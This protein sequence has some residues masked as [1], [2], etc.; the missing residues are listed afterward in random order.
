MAI[1]RFLVRMKVLI[2]RFKAAVENYKKHF[3]RN[4]RGIWLPECAYRP[5]YDWHSM[6]PVAPYHQKHLRPGIEQFLAKFDIEYFVTDQDLTERSWQ[7]SELI[8]MLKSRDS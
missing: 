3:G 4:P 6:I 1:C 8:L 7:I 5:S 2:C